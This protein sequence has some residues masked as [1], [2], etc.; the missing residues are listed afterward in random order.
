MSRARSQFQHTPLWAALASTLADL[1]STGEV[2]VD[3]NVDYVIDYL[4]RELVAKH[5]VTSA[6]AQVAPGR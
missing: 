4:C 6:A 3:T 1:Q 5:M 2:R